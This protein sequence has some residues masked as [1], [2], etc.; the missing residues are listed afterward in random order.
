MNARIQ[1]LGGNLFLV[2]SND[3]LLT[4][5]VSYET[6]VAVRN[7]EGVVFRT[8]T[9]WSRSTEAHI[10]AFQNAP[11][12]RPGYEWLQDNIDQALIELTGSP[13][14]TGKAVAAKL[15]RTVDTELG[16]DGYDAHTEAGD[17]NLVVQPRRSRRAAR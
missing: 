13:R 7:A 1:K 6:P 2:G 14:L 4:V 15:G 11:G 10:R 3:G 8:K 12:S 17:R 9:R 16:I 5:L